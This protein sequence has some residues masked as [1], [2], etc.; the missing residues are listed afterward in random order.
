MKTVLDNKKTY[1]GTV[2]YMEANR[3]S[4]FIAL[5]Q[6]AYRNRY[7]IIGDCYVQKNSFYTCF[8]LA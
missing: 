5:I 7:L 8:D 4:F 3:I 1:N 6:T 2:P